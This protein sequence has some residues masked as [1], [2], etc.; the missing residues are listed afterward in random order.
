MYSIR[1]YTSILYYTLYIYIH[2]YTY[3]HTHITTGGR[4][5]GRNVA[6][7][8]R[9]RRGALASRAAGSGPFSYG[10]S[11]TSGSTQVLIRSVL[12]LFSPACH[13]PRVRAHVGIG[14]FLPRSCR[15]HGRSIL[16]HSS[17]RYLQVA[18]VP[19]V[20]CQTLV[21]GHCPY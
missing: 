1:Y 7:V 2:T 8:A 14:A 15:F 12:I 17:R 3:M 16:P 21:F 5:R 18:S 20:F 9:K 4:G 6:H 10:L 11:D 13:L 19:M